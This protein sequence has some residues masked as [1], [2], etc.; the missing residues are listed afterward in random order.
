MVRFLIFRPIA[1]CVVALTLMG[2]GI[3]V[4]KLLPI[5]LL[6]DVPV[7]EIT[8]QASLQGAD[9]RQVQQVVALP[10]RNQLLQL[11]RLEDI[12][13]VSHDGQVIVKLKFEYGA[14]IDLAYLETNEKIDKLMES[15][16]RTMSRPNVIK[17][18]AGDIPVFQLNVWQEGGSG[19]LLELSAFSEGILKRRLEQLPEIAFVDMTGLVH[20][21]ILIQP[22]TD[23]LQHSGISLDDLASAI[24]SHSGDIGNLT[25]K[26]GP[27]E[28]SISF[29]ATLNTKEDIENLYFRIGAASSRLVRLGDLAK[30]SLIAKSISGA[31]VFNG[32]RAVGLAII[33]Q[34]NAQLLKLRETLAH[35]IGVFR[36]E[37]PNLKFQ[38]S[39]DQTAL[40]DLSVSN[41][42]NSLVVGAILSFVMIMFF[43]RDKRLVLLVGLVIPVSLTITLLGFYLLGLSINIVSL[44]GLVLGMGE[45]VDSAIIIIENIEQR[46][47]EESERKSYSLA[48]ACIG[49]AEE[50]IRPLFTSVL[51]N[52]AVFL[53]LIFL[54][55]IA[56][57]LF[58]EQA[59]AVSLALA[60][61][62]LTSYTL[63]PVLY[64]Q[65]FKRAG[66]TRSG[67]TFASA[68]AAKIYNAIF[69]FA[70][71]R[72]VA[73]L[74]SWLLLMVLV[75]YIGE[76]IEKTGMPPIRHVE[77]EAHINWNEPLSTEEN[78]RRSTL[79]METVNVKPKE[80]GLFI[81]QQQFLLNSRLQQASSEALLVAKVQD[82]AAFDSLWKDLD[83]NLKRS[84]PNA[85]FE[86]RPAMNV[87]EQL[88][89]TYDAP[90]QLRLS[91][92]NTQQIPSLR[93]TDSTSNLLA[94]S[95]I[96]VQ[97][98]PR[99]ERTLLHI[100]YDR[101]LLYGVSSGDLLRALRIK[102][103]D[104]EV[105]TMRSLQ[106]HVPILLGSDSSEESLRGLFGN[107]FVKTSY[108]G[109]VA[110]KELVYHSRD[111]DYASLFLGADGPYV[112]LTPEMKV[113]DVP[114]LR[115][116]I[117][118]TMQE[119]PSLS[120]N[121]AGSYYRNMSYLKDLIG[122]VVVSLGML[123]F[124]LAAQFESLKQPFIVL[125][126]ILFGTAGALITLYIAGS[127]IN[128]MSAIG[129]VVL[130]GL[131][132]NDSILK[133]DSMNRAKD[134]LTLKEVIR[135][136]GEKRLQSQ[137]MT[138]FTTVLGLAPVLW[139]SG[140]GADL[141]KPLA[142]AVIGGMIL[143]VFISWTFIPLTYF[144]LNKN[145]LDTNSKYSPNAL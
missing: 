115:E 77:L 1:T 29:E 145:K 5:S 107:T 41:L 113:S 47:E 74:I 57:T 129:F 132:D 69:N 118:R 94:D 120:A 83:W 95:G 139:S 45:I 58:L 60:V 15:L 108:G 92:K 22:H 86:L 9:A 75:Y 11:D 62:L 135:I 134:T 53:P 143:G 49:G 144:W 24:E 67:Q 101:L 125:L 99:R 117:E 137:L 96:T 26:D 42:V 90:L 87:F 28:Y 23:L 98:P 59:I 110:V 84:F 121:F 104:H 3:I 17:G 65:F 138:F 12:E 35:Q 13:A 109:Q 80:V 111:M 88:F 30:V 71:K 112:P 44:A 8:V 131:L 116:Q 37:Y 114:T 64:Y 48:D 2:L 72:P 50:V 136:G 124:I 52:S 10:L 46:L 127:S 56:G 61:S 142:L 93:I 6:P 76:K 39:Q 128:V 68:Q 27:Y 51:T 102:L 16:P 36:R 81:G 54:S 32:K 19:D 126:T 18:G 20:A 105:G 33:K 130:I 73:L 4:T 141:Q 43:M 66:R 55:G 122:I 91:T 78:L 40:L 82:P 31:Y 14:D 25:V 97:A 103:D 34:N 85:L 70:L 106:M 89:Q 133:I 21:Q 38:I 119:L 100:R 63:I 79:L 7:P 140:L 123:F